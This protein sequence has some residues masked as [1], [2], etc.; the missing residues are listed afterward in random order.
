MRYYTVD[1]R[2]SI[3]ITIIIII[4]YRVCTA[5]KSAT[6]GRLGSNVTLRDIVY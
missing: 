2:L 1:R 5:D 3:I 4:G 6:L